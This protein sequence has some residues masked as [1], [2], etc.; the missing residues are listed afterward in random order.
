MVPPKGQI[1]PPGTIADDGPAQGA[2]LLYKIQIVSLDNRPLELKIVD[3]EKPERNAASAELGRLSRSACQAASS[4][5]RATGAAV[6]SAGAVFDEHHADHD[7]RMQRRGER[8]EPGVGVGGF[9]FGLRLAAF[10]ARFAGI[11]SSSLPRSMRRVSRRSSVRRCRSCRRPSPRESRRPSR[12]LRARRRS[13]GAARCAPPTALVTC[14]PAVVAARAAGTSARP[15]A[16]RRRWSRPRSP[17]PAGR[18][19]PAPG[20]SPW[21]RRRVPPGSG[22]P[23]GSVLSAA[24]AM[25]GF[26]VEAEPFGGG[27]QTRR[28][29]L[30]PERGEHGVARHGEGQFQRAAAV[31]AVGVVQP[32]PVERGERRVREDGARSGD[33]RRQ[34]AGDGDHLERRARWL[35]AIEAEARHGQDL[36]GR[37]LHGDDPAEL[38]AERGHRRALQRGGDGG[39]N[40]RRRMG[41][42]VGER[43]R[44]PPAALRRGCP[45]GDRRARAPGRSGRRSLAAARPVLPAPG[46]AQ[47]GTGPTVA[48]DGVRQIAE[49]GVASRFRR[50]APAATLRAGFRP[51]RCRRGPAASRAAAALVRRLSS[52]PGRRPGN[53][54][55]RDH[56]MRVPVAGAL[57][58]S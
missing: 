26:V 35:Q 47:A 8:G 13:S 6:A 49:R 1:P 40:G 12:S 18:P 7:P 58:R 29:E 33:P 31:L 53:A 46:G 28:A 2:V 27:H 19:G 17:S 9:A 16:R 37:G 4:T 34:H 55:E 45:A 11:P 48:D 14:T 36:P 43:T 21:I 41:R 56:A 50:R 15:R 24:P 25:P 23:A 5:C 51:A 10:L 38:A 42:G 32:H 22:W 39:A 44:A 20:R 57:R 30:D 52:S 3:P 54:S